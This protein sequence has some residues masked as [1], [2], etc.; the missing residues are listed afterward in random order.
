[1]RTPDLTLRYLGTP[2]YK[3]HDGWR[4]RRGGRCVQCAEIVGRDRRALINDACDES[5]PRRRAEF[6]AD[7][8][9][10]A[11]HLYKA[12]LD[13]WAAKDRQVRGWRQALA[14]HGLTQRLAAELRRYAYKRQTGEDWKT[15]AQATKEK[16]AQL[17]AGDWLD[18]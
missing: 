2:C 14:R 1:M 6:Q 16:A 13:L 15:K 7:I 10:A 17:P 4:Y 11:E 18:E 9:R 3:G 5:R 8:D 12:G